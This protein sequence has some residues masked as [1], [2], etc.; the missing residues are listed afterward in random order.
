MVLF[1]FKKGRSSCLNNNDE[2]EVESEKHTNVNFDQDYKEYFPEFKEKIERNL[3]EM[4]NTQYGT[5]VLHTILNVCF[6][7]F[8]I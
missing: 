1:R 4:L 5:Y 3:F 6:F 7:I 8:L 2:K